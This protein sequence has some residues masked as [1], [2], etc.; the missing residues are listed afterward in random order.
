MP[1][2]T[3][4]QEDLAR[5]KAD[6]EQ[7]DR[8]YND[9]LSALDWALTAKPDL[10][11]PPPD[12]DDHQISPLNEGWRV[13]PD[14]GPDLGGGWRARVYGLV[15]RLMGPL[16]QR[17][18][19]F[20]GMLVDHL[21]RN[22]QVA[23][24]SGRSATSALAAVDAHIDAVVTFQSRLIQ[25]LQCLTPYV[26]T[27]DYEAAGLARRINEDVASMAGDLDRRTLGLVGA[28]DG[29]TDEMR[30]RAESSLA[31]EQRF[32]QHVNEL[33][34][35]VG[36]VQ[37]GLL[38]VRTAMEPLAD[39]TA[40]TGRTGALDV[41]ALDDSIDAYTYVGFENLFRGAQEEIRARL[42]DY[43]PLF[44]GASDVL[45]LGCGR[46]EFLDLL[47]ESGVSSRGLDIN[48]EMVEEC[49]ARGLEAET[50]DA[51]T[52]LQAVPDD[53]LGGLFAAQVV[54][55]LQPDYLVRLLG[56]A[57]RKLRPGATIVL[58]T[59]NPAC[60]FAFFD[61]YVRDI[62][63]IRPLHPDTLQYLI[64]ASGFHDTTIRYSAP[65]PDDAKLQRVN[66]PA[67]GNA[68][69]DDDS[70]TLAAVASTLNA[71]VDKLNA[72]L[73]TYLDYAAIGTRARIS[74][75]T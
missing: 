65:Y 34:T 24:E 47:R 21:N 37:H 13:V 51:L 52:Y 66:V 72:L 2:R 39:G 70:A 25:Y 56:V 46:G 75:V 29:V 18:Q 55:H 43:L 59:V 49:R 17:Q 14:E 63:H 35:T 19:H 11:H 16:I 71:N 62:T 60:W 54:E 31:R 58:E 41:T 27:K 4:R 68:P 73:F 42:R 33:R 26:N 45:D 50:G 30:K 53:S 9:A 12:F 64:A 20:N 48:A 69:D 5:F 74:T 38:A 36:Q 44:A 28:L 3:V 22:A 23:K 61:A 32:L 10:P 8:E 57:G 1:K 6:R 67:A 15:W 7:A 40:T